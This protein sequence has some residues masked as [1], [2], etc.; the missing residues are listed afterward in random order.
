MPKRRVGRL[1][2]AS[3]TE[4]GPP[5]PTDRRPPKVGCSFPPP[6]RA[7]AVV[8]HGGAAPGTRYLHVDHLGSVDVITRDDGSI[9]ER[10]SYDAF[11][12]RRN[13]EWGGPSGSFTS[14]TTRGFT[15]H[16]E[17]D[18]FGL[19]N[20]KGRIMDPRL[21]RFTTTDAVIADIW[22]GQSLNRY[23]YVLNNPLALVDPTGFVPN[24]PDEPAPGRT[25]TL[26]ETP[27]PSIT[28]L[29]QSNSIVPLPQTN[30]APTPERE[31]AEV[32][33]YAPPVDVNTT[34]TG[35]EGLPQDTPEVEPIRPSRGLR[36]GVLDGMFDP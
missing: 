34:G 3:G 30:M 22:D 2:R 5:L 4:E 10:R 15:G 14:R 19:V 12:A 20:M 31:A 36:D 13:P 11:G 33:A 35:G 17:D 29:V 18:E 23:A 6:E 8:T 16:E 32:G 1:D 25:E 7:I 26:V 28:Y 24:E 21:G 27:P 9:D